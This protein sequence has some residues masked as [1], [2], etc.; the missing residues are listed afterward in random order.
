MTP[1]G[2]TREGA[3]RKS[4]FPGK[5]LERTVYMDFTPAGRQA[6]DVLT[7]REGLSRN[8]VL[9]HLSLRYAD[10]LSFDC[11]GV[12]FPGKAQAAMTIRLPADALQ[13]LERAHARTGKSYS[14]LGEALVLWHGQEEHAFPLLPE[15]ERKPKARR[16]RRR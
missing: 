15:P 6:L 11:E 13:V 8:D 4:A 1:R 5:L 9:A 7:A 3:G 14:D 12:V 10:Q 2:G 16:P